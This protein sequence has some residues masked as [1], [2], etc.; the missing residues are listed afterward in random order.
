MPLL[1]VPS[2]AP[3]GLTVK[4]RNLFTKFTLLGCAKRHKARSACGHTRQAISE[5]KVD[6]GHEKAGKDRSLLGADQI[7]RLRHVYLVNPNGFLL[8]IQGPL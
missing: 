6:L 3:W 8:A 7:E 2:F 1:Y 4:S 5:G